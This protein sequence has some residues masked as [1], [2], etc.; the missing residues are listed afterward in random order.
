MASSS[1]PS[2]VKADTDTPQEQVFINFR[3]VELRYNFVSHLEK[4]LKRNAINAFIDT[5]EE[6]GQELN[7]LLK[8]IEGSRIALAIFSPKYTESNWCL[9]ELAKMKERMEQS[10][11][12]VIPIFY[13]V[14][15][16]T[17]KELKGEFGDNFREL[18]KSIDK[19]TKSQWKEALKSV[20]LLMGFTL[21]EK[22]YEGEIITKVVMEVK[23]VLNRLS[24]ASL[25]PP[26]CNGLSPQR[27]Q[28]SR[29]SSWGIEHRLKQL[30]EKLSS[31][32]EETTR[33]IGVVGMPGIGKTT[34]ARNL[35]EKLND[36][37]LSHVLIPD[38]HDISKQHGSKEQI[39]VLLGNRDWIKPGSNIVI[40]TSDKSLIQN[41]VDD[42]YE[43]PRLS[44]RDAFKHFIHYAFDDQQ[45]DHALE[46]GKFRKLSK[47]F[48]HYTKGN[49]LALKILGAELLGKDETHWEL[50]LAALNQHHKSPPGQSTSKMLHNVWKGSYG[51]LSQQQKDTLLDIA[52]FKSLDENYVMSLLDSDGAMNEVQ[53]LVNKFMINIYAGKVEM[54]DTLYMLIKEL[55]QEAT[56]ADGKGRHMLWYHRTIMDVLQRNKGA[57]NVRSIF[58]DLSDITR[59][60]SFHSHAF[61]KM[62]D[63]RYLK[64]YSTHCPQ[65]CDRDIKLNFPEGLQLPLNEVR[66]LHW[67]K[68][69]LKEVPQDFN[70]V[71][72]VDLKLPYS[73]IEH[74]WEDN[75]DTS[76]LKWVDLNHSRNLSTLSGLG[77][78][79]N[80]Q[81]LYL[82][83]CT[84]L[85]M[86]DI[87][88][89]N[90]KCL[91]FL[92]L[93]G[94]TSLQSLPEIKLI[95]LKTLILSDCSK[96]K[97]FLVIS[98]KL[99]ALY[100]DGTTVKELPCDFLILQ[101]LVLLNMRGCKKLKRF[102]CNFG[103]L[104]SLEE[105]ILSG[106][107]KLK[108]LPES[109]K[110][111]S[112][113]EILH[114]DETSIEEIPIIFSVRSLCLSRNED[115]RRLPDLINQFS[116]LQ[117]LDLKY[118]TNLTH[119]PQLPPNL[120][121]L[122]V[123]GCSS[124]KT[125]AKP[126]VCSVPVEDIHSK[127]IF[128]NCN[129]L[130]IAAKE[131]IVVYAKQKCQFLSSALK[132]RN[133]GCVPEILFDTSFPGCEMPSWFSHEAIGSMVEFE[134][135]PHW[136]HNRLYGIALCVVVSFHN[137][138][139]HT[140]LL[141][142]FTSEQK[143]REGSCP[144]ITWKVGNLIE[145]ADEEEKVE[146]DHVFIGYTNCLDLVHLVEG[147]GPPKCAPTKASLEFI[148]TPTGTSG[149]ARF[150]V[151]RSGFSFVFEP[152]EN[153]VSFPR[154][155]DEV[156]GNTKIKGT[157]TVNGCVKDQAN[158]DESCKGPVADLH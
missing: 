73:K 21:D 156:S 35:Y 97:T 149:K 27:H 43:V 95:S 60:M 131:E 94:C 109:G 13:K 34:L 50:K 128:T 11:L 45:G 56:A 19:K 16:A 40:A 155:H 117:C 23:Q 126:L 84:A 4:C 88:M 31:G 3:G 150:E 148:V 105:L 89:Q 80:L 142:K 123:S 116:R 63:L 41:L 37:F 87:D 46:L 20:P 75:K 145:H 65:E 130:E 119:V 7:V 146:S 52:C 124:L 111:M 82:E 18:V 39:D 57:F 93:R 99:E 77:K 132:H 92:N 81:E 42:F 136:N 100:L 83:G 22:S 51:G 38:I 137:C 153:K 48:V 151:L 68:F 129:E 143:T 66:C 32:L 78:A 1:S 118:C 2:R 53:N 102:P 29:E 158:G 69:P 30:E 36:G 134:L 70:P 106:C 144:G 90:M 96:F 110:N 147:Q 8:R 26:E 59:K 76:N 55:G 44:D 140:N 58:L 64:I 17:V 25:S 74:V 15:P 141:V 5:D 24:K 127:F 98:D 112:R 62:S 12:V 157:P 47:G 103:E 154:N 6:K 125:I 67:L 71:N 108:E 33:V 86:L 139:N 152:E 91:V 104:K 121:C 138:Q 61:A 72:L 54:H 85:K 113:L 114:L 9:K 115:I 135:P 107:S 133:G 79:Q 14:E 120:Q 101:R 122:D 28:K 10:K 49:P